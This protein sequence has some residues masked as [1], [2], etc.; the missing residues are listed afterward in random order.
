MHAIQY[1]ITSLQETG[2]YIVVEQIMKHEDYQSI[3]SHPNDVA[4]LKVMYFSVTISSNVVLIL[5][6]F[7]DVDDFKLLPSLNAIESNIEISCQ[8][9]C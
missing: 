4:I 3:V 1:G 6:T 8:K 9:S 7:S 2:N 5:G